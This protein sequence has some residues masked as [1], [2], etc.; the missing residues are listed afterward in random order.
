[1]KDPVPTP[2]NKEKFQNIQVT[3]IDYE[4]NKLFTYLISLKRKLKI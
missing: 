4:S 1:M 2:E 3:D